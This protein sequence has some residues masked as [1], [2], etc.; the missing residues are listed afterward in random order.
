MP[1]LLALE[2]LPRGMSEWLTYRE[3]AE[4]VGRSKRALQRWRRHGM[5]MQLDAE[6]RRIVHETTLFACIARTS[7]RG[8]HTR[9]SSAE[10]CATR[11]VARRLDRPLVSPPTLSVEQVGRSAIAT[12]PFS[13][14]PGCAAHGRWCRAPSIH[15]NVFKTQQQH[16]DGDRHCSRGQCLRRRIEPV[17]PGAFA[18][19]RNRSS[20]E[21]PHQVF[22]DVV[23][24]AR[25][26]GVIT[27]I[28]PCIRQPV[29][30]AR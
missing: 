5:P 23:K 10:S 18:G 24:L 16:Y 27:E 4:Q 21:L 13:F 3:A 15:E 20:M 28:V 7:K 22:D 19:L 25:P 8:L 11:R 17:G 29:D 2:G 30:T 6:G 12:G 9:R 26:G 14:L 1:G